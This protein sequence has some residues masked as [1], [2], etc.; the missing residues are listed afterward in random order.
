M[1]EQ[2]R[3]VATRQVEE[4]MTQLV[5]ETGLRCCICLEGYKNQP[6]KVEVVLINTVVGISNKKFLNR[7][8]E[9]TLSLEGLYWMSLR[10]SRER[11]M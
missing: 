7:L 5:E 11:H 1:D 3:V 10:T 9:C 2:G 8:L 4:E 6:K